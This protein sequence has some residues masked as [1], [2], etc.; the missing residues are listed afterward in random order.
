MRFLIIIIFVISTVSCGTKAD[1]NDEAAVDSAAQAEK[2]KVQ[3]DSIRKLYHQFHSELN[4]PLP[5]KCVAES[6]KVKVRE[7]EEAQ[8]AVLKVIRAMEA[9]K[10]IQLIVIDE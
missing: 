3:K 8:N 10:E 5:S 6:G 2:V 9:A 7:A 4:D 1:S